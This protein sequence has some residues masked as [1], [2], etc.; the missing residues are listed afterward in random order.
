MIKQVDVAI[1]EEHLEPALDTVH[2]PLPGPMNVVGGVCSKVVGAGPSQCHAG[3][4]DRC[5][6][7]FDPCP[8]DV[9]GLPIPA[10][11]PASVVPHARV[12]S[13]ASLFTRGE[14]C[15]RCRSAYVNRFYL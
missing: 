1:E 11:P 8:L 13:Q 10:D 6:L 2:D 7:T 9:R 14:G 5:F 12:V 3:R 4:M 15:V